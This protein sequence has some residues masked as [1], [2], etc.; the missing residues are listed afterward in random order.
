MAFGR[1]H[2]FDRNRTLEVADAARA[3]GRRFKAIAEYQK[4]LTHHPDDAAV[5]G[6]LA[7]L[8]ADVNKKPEA[9]ES[10]RAAADSHTGK[11]FVD[12][13]I[14]VYGQAVDYFPKELDLWEKIVSLHV[15][16]GR[17]ADAVKVL[18]RARTKIDRRGDRLQA[19]RWLR[20]ALELEPNHI[21]ATVDLARLLA[22]EGNA[23]EALLLVRSLTPNVAG[24]SRRRLRRAEF[25]V[26]P[27]PK[28]LWRWWFAG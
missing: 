27:S 14:A 1:K 28:T 20:R 11:G 7:P 18:L 19:I 17:T 4:I 21:D 6:K 15:E 26:A 12:R 8:L 23:P 9:L 3:K 13:A 5:H 25:S 22:K 16:R 10:F 24:P 2:P